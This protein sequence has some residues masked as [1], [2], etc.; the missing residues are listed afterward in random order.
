MS[1][2]F[3]VS[4]Y[5]TDM[6]FFRPPLSECNIFIADGVTSTLGIDT[7]AG[8]G[9]SS[10]LS[11]VAEPRRPVTAQERQREREEKRRK[12]QERARERERKMKEKERREG[13]QGDLLG[14]V[15]LSDN[16]KSL[17]QRWTMMMDR[18]NDKSQI[19]NNDGAKN[20]DCNVNSHQCVAMGDNAQGALN[21]K[22]DKEARK[23][24]SHQQ[25]ISEVKTN[26]QG[27]FQPTSTQQPSLLFSMNQRK[28]PA[29]I[30]VTV[31]GGIGIMNV[32]SGFVKNNM[33]KPYSESNGQSGFSCLGNWS[34]Q[35]L[36][37]RPPQPNRKPQPPT[38]G[39]LQPQLQPQTQH[40]P[41]PQLISLENYLTK[42]PTLT[43]REKNGNLDIGGH[44]NHKSQHNPSTASAMEKLCPS[45]G[46]KSGAQTTN[47]LCGALEVTSHPHPS[48]G[49]S[50]TGQ[51]GP[52]IAPDI[53]TVTLQ[54]SKSQVCLRFH[55]LHFAY[56]VKYSITSFYQVCVERALLLLY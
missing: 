52:S 25:L 2:R 14:G 39:F 40:D 47:P 12:R 8:G 51:Q 7:G 50:D 17:L 45:V 11:S 48:L 56:L 31:S 41:Q 1:S 6:S 29:D 10:S 26:Q 34:G 30:V 33:L 23:S 37:T 54:L 32:T 24:Q 53:H 16:D 21:N 22:T 46:E 19:L 18:G 4:T 27:I 13:K 44:N 49:F 43:M 42:A 38:T 36:E 15:L 35:Q 28:P 20:K 9:V 3:S 5:I 55:L